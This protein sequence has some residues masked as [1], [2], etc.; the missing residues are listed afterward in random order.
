LRTAPTRAPPTRSI[1][2]RTRS[3]ARCGTNCLRTLLANRRRAPGGLAA[4]E[5]P[6]LLP[7]TPTRGSTR[8]RTTRTRR[9]AGG[10][11]DHRERA[12]S[13]PKRQCG[14]FGQAGP[15]SS[16]LVHA[17]KR[18]ETRRGSSRSYAAAKRSASGS[19]TPTGSRGRSGRARSSRPR[20]R[21]APARGRD[22]RRRSPLGL[23]DGR[24]P[25]VARGRHE[26]APT[27]AATNLNPTAAATNPKRR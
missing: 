1:R 7:R 22:P 6:P 20:L 2:R 3:S 27:S 23:G 16:G 13:N 8:C 10:R 17:E 15:P 9:C 12:R 5:R 11:A 24:V 26:D 21:A 4:L 18:E 25:R 19:A 14:L